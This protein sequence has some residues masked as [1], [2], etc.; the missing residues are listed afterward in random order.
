M[1]MDWGVVG[2]EAGLAGPAVVAEGL[3][4]MV[5]GVMAA[6]TVKV[7]VVGVAWVATAGTVLQVVAWG[8]VALAGWGLMAGTASTTGS[9]L[10]MCCLHR[11]PRRCC[12]TSLQ[13]IGPQSLHTAATA[14]T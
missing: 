1:G 9:A 10:R 7:G 5:P 2:V 12:R 8:I 13:G 14:G 3:L 4:V 6:V 11:C